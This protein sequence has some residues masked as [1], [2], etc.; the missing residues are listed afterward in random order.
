[1]AR[2]D[3][4]FLL[5]CTEC[6]DILRLDEAVKRSCMC[7]KSTATYDARGKIM[8]EGP[9]R[10]ISITYEDYD[11]AAPGEAKK[12]RVAPRSG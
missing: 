6:D 7:K 8:T 5:N 10:L 11:S 2:D 3:C 1:V 12:W 4:F 9:V